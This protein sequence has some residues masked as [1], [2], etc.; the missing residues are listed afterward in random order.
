MIALLTSPPV[1]PASMPKNPPINSARATG[2]PPANRDTLPAHTIRHH[3]APP[4]HVGAEPMTRITHWFEPPQYRTLIRVMHR[5]V[6]REDHHDEQ[7]GEHRTHRQG[8][9]V[10]A[11]TPPDAPPIALALLCTAQCLGGPFRLGDGEGGRVN[12]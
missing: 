6:R 10:A 4:D 2:T 12:H 3:T 9:L 7:Q 11:Q 1:E 8:D 5:E